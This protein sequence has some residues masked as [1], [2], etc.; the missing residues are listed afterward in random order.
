MKL[1]NV[2][3]LIL[4][5]A[6]GTGAYL[7][8]LALRFDGAIPTYYWGNFWRWVPLAL[9][10]HILFN[11]AFGLYGRM[12]RYA[13]VHEV[14][15]LILSGA[16]AGSVV[17]TAGSFAGALGGLRPLP[18]S[19]LASGAVLSIVGFGAMRFQSRLFVFRKGSFAE[20]PHRVLVVGAG[21][22][23]AMLIRDLQRNKSLGLDPAGLVDDD[24][25][26]QGRS[27]HGLRVL[28]ALGDLPSLV[29]S[30]NIDQ[31]LLAIPSA[32]S[33]LVRE[34]SALCEEADVILR[35][36]PSVGEIV[37]ERVSAG[38][39][40]DLQ[41]ED[42]LGRRQVEIDF[43]S[44]KTIIRDRRVLV[45]GAGGS[46]GSEIVRQ[47]AAFGPAEIQLLD[48]DETHLHEIVTELENRVMLRSVLADIRDR[49]KLFSVFTRCRP[50]IVFH[51]AAHKH[52]PI[53]ETHPEEALRTNVLGTANVADATVSAGAK[54]FVLIS[55]D[56]AINPSS[57]MGASKWL[58][59]QVV[60]IGEHNGCVFSAVRFGNVL[61][62]RGSVIPTFLSQIGR[63]DAVTVTDPAMTRYFMSAQEAVR[64]VLQAAAF[65]Q[66]GEIFTLEMGEPVNI[67]ELARKLIRLSGKV[68]DKQIPIQ[69][70][71]P[72]PGEKLAEQVRHDD[73]PLEPSG[74]PSILVSRPSAPDAAELRIAL[75]ELER[76]AEQERLDELVDLFMRIAHREVPVS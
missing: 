52:V 70:V 21:E 55:T 68:P 29:A 60:R 2:P 49:N 19:V 26:K 72:R 10:I 75:Q 15:R 64:L 56:K 65:S 71:G 61:G 66:G 8:S 20:T 6:A 23:G 47:V 62:S 18:I 54:R 27:M 40:R 28:G 42:I 44:V 69:I 34:V 30:M 24:P 41:I 39:I 14:R 12:W 4:D 76:L 43:V 73:E 17:V 3:L 57:I 22:A 46:V 9:C 33:E 59:E 32:T 25:R 31:V 1:R 16:L 36:L 74:H 67:G 5:L 50:E 7:A 63:G 38:D 13:S 37:G 48:H 11:Y 58:A 35:V 45:T 53:L 51:A